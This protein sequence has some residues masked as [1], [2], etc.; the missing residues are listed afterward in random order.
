MLCSSELNKREKNTT[1]F[2][3]K[4]YISLLEGSVMAHIT[5]GYPDI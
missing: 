5:M 1:V 3:S 4:M 2:M